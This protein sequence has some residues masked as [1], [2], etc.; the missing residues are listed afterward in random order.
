MYKLA[1]CTVATN[2]FDYFGASMKGPLINSTCHA[3]VRQAVGAVDPD[4]S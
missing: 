1:H 2:T 3:A 4:V